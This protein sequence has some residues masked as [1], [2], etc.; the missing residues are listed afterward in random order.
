MTN[1][2]VTES[3]SK[4]EKLRYAVIAIKK[5]KSITL[6]RNK[7]KMDSLKLSVFLTQFEEIHSSLPESCDLSFSP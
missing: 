6:D 3:T 5:F 4:K 1:S 2:P 7:Y